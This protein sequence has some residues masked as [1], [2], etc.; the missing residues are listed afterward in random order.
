MKKSHRHLWFIILILVVICDATVTCPAQA[1][2][3]YQPSQSIT[4]TIRIWGDEYMSGVTSAWQKGFQKYHPQVNFET[5]LMGSATA[6][7][8]IYTGVADLALIGRETNTTDNDG[9]LH[10]LQY[11]P[12]RF[13]LMTGSLDRPGKSYALAIFVHK[14]NPLS[15]LT[16]TQLDA[17]FG[18]E[19]RRGLDNIRTWGQLGLAGEWKNK[20]INLYSYDA[21][22]GTGLFFLHAVLAD[23]RK[24]NWETL[25]EFKDIKAPSGSTYES[26]QQIIDA[27]RKDRFGLAVSSVRYANAEVKALPLAA[28]DSG[29]YLMATRENLISRQYPLTRATYAF[30]NQLPDKPIDPKVRE[31]LRYV[32]SREGQEDIARDH[33]YLPLSQEAIREQ[34]KKLN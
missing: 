7:P 12:L 32:F 16:L 4:G 3:P 13:E 29:P 33:G 30:V 23:S 25:K 9:F 22:T 20:S 8:G 28:Y 5:K 31:F 34:L 27:L 17:V 21:E 19:H 18:C 11:R 26:G 24:M 15:K 1:G 6:M 10:V 2:A 14:D